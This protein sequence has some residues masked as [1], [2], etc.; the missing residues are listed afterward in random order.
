MTVALLYSIALPSALRIHNML[1]ETEISFVVRKLRRS[2]P[3]RSALQLR[4]GQRSI[5]GV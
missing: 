1:K 5:S 4:M 3:A 2:F